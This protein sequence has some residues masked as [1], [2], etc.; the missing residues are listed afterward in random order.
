MKIAKIIIILLMLTFTVIFFIENMDPVPMY[1]PIVKVRKVGLIF[2]MLASYCMGALT[3]FVVI[4]GVGVKIR[5]KRKLQELG[6]DQEE[7]FEDE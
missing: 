4:T 5:K 2:I 3:T 6:E 1:M 7:L